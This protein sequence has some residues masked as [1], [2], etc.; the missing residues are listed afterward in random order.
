[1]F[2]LV[3]RGSV[4]YMRLP[5]WRNHACAASVV[6]LW[7]TIWLADMVQI[8]RAIS[9][10]GTQNIF[11]HNRGKTLKFLEILYCW[12]LKSTDP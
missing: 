9:L 10:L 6:S 11:G 4:F 2:V 12:Y 8:R 7:Q 5:L 1:M 3:W